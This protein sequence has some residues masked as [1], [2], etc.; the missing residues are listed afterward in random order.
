MTKKQKQFRTYDDIFL[1][2]LGEIEPATHAQIA[3][4]LGM[5][6]PPH[7]IIRN[8]IKKGLIERNTKTF[9][10]TFSVK[11]RFVSYD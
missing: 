3:R 10:S 11:E 2:A 6:H 4:K 7:S 1:E 8:A 5:K 9:P